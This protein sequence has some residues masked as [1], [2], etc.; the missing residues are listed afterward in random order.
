M[1][2]LAY[3]AILLAL[4]TTAASAQTIPRALQAPADG[5]PAQLLRVHH[6]ATDSGPA[7]QM[8]TS[9]PSEA[10]TVT[11]WYKQSVYD[12]SNNKVGEIMDVL[13][14]HDG[15]NV[16]I[17]IGVGGFLGIGEKDVAVPFDAVRFKKK[18]NNSW[19]PVMN[20][21]KDAL[22]NAQGY[23][24]DRNAMKWM[25]ENAPA[26]IGGPNPAPRPNPR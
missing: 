13:I 2:K 12:L 10:W 23:K 9:L 6:E 4:T 19:Y 22:Q 5:Q 20:T 11:D 1:T 8:L 21:T 7:V 14:D 15:K 18:D 24:Y 25:P 3:T 17:I 26:T 16:A